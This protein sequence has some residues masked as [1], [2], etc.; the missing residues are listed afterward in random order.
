MKLTVIGSN[1]CPDTIEAL[2]ELTAK[3]IIFEFLNISESLDSLKEFLYEREHNP[4]YEEVKKHQG[5][6]IPFFIL[7][8]GTKTFSIET[9]IAKLGA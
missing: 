5:I 7:E 6:G 4:I 9:I 8:D 1:L 3:N 2:D